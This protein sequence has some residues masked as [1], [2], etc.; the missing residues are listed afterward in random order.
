MA[1]SCDACGKKIEESYGNTGYDLCS[2]CDREL[3]KVIDEFVKNH[4]KA[5]SLK[6][7]GKDKR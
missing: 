4:K 3:D 7:E 6:A 5:P 2:K 1:L